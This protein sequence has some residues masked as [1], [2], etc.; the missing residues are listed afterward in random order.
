M[1]VNVVDASALERNL[2]FNLQLLELEPTI[3]VALNQV[4]LVE[5]KRIRVELEKLAKLLGVPVIPII[6]TKKVG[7]HEVMEA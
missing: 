5:S 3:L 4:E 1:I 2:F 7:L 6:T